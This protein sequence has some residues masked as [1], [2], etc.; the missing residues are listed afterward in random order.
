MLEIIGALKDANIPTILAIVGAI[1]I[2][3]AIGVEG[4]LR[5]KPDRRR[6]AGIVGS[7]FFCISIVLFLV[8][9]SP[10]TGMSTSLPLPT[11]PIT[12]TAVPPT[13]S[14]LISTDTPT[15]IPTDTPTNTLTDTL[16]LEDKTARD[17]YESGYNYYTRVIG[18]NW[19]SREQAISDLTQ[20]I[21]EWSAY[22]TISGC[23][24]SRDRECV[25]I[26]GALGIAHYIRGKPQDIELAFAYYEKSINRDEDYLVAHFQRGAIYYNLGKYD[27][28]LQDFDNVIRI[29]DSSPT[30]IKKS[31]TDY[32]TDSYCF[33][34]KS[35]DNLGRTA[36]A[37]KDEA[38]YEQLKAGSTCK[39]AVDN[40][41]DIWHF[42]AR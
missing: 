11:T 13:T 8:P 24:Q 36:D 28:A 26:F 6:L 17:Y 35:L 18:N 5:L 20:A 32:R 38:A 27:K 39:I 9:T 23:E 22:I 19:R 2:L 34:A 3:L 21:K 4:G 33:R 31:I 7:L 41:L 12:Q 42:P 1:L 15:P 29:Y 14:T 25:E 30:E 16:T 37:K 40:W 10:T